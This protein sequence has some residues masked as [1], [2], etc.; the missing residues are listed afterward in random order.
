LF[1]LLQI[2]ALEPPTGGAPGTI[3]GIVASSVS[4][5][6]IS[7]ARI[8]IGSRSFNTEAV[9]DS[10]GRFLIPNTPA[11][12]YRIEVTATGYGVPATPAYF[13]PVR[14]ESVVV[15]AGRQ[16]QPRILLTPAATIRGRVLDDNG[17]GIPDT[18]VE[19]L[20][21][22]T[23][24]DGKSEWTSVRKH[25]TPETPLEIRT[26]AQGE[27]E[28]D[29]L[30]SG[31]YYVRAVLS[32]GNE[33]P[34]R[35][36]Y[37]DTVDSSTAARV[38]LSE[39]GRTTIDIHA[40]SALL[41]RRYTVSGTVAYPVK[42]PNVC[43]LLERRNREGA[44]EST[45][46]TLTADPGDP[47]SRHFEIRGAIPGNYDLT[48]WGVL[49]E[50][51]PRS[52]A[53]KGAIEV[54]DSD[55]SNVRLVLRPAIDVKGK[56]VTEDN[57][58]SQFSQERPDGRTR[59][60]SR[61]HVGDVEIVIHRKDGLFAGADIRPV[62]SEDG[63]SFA[64]PNT[65]EGEYE[66][67][68]RIVADDRPPRPDLYVADIRAGGRSV[69]DTGFQVGVDAVDSMEI[70][71]GTQ[72]GSIQGSIPDSGAMRIAVILAPESFRR[73]NAALYHISYSLFL[74][75]RF[76]LSG[77]APGNYVV[78]AVPYL[79]RSLPYRNPEF[80]GKYERR[81]IR[82]TVQKGSKIIGLKVPLLESSN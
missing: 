41:S 57:L 11:G 18:L 52:Y 62:L 36:Y 78:F 28:H 54:R 29:A 68:T 48:A 6:P 31:D 40:T 58:D 12:I 19:V 82:V 67:R 34:L 3:D 74:D 77:I 64:F 26:N 38:V 61:S 21:V 37:P 76:S 46:A 75:G 44:R 2:F 55:V 72:G 60:A 8:K 51:N 39:G 5:W 10:A 35:I 47:L 9:T 63:R 33:L 43:V 22:F 79:D 7:G 59:D 14:T 16:V 56:L 49:E 66:I 20:K 80:V 1:I 81:A 13:N 50:L 70:V 42:G 25:E 32:S 71:L 4:G 73:E 69:F 27:Y 45:C 17:H 65:I 53:S 30:G 24:E 23:R 15:N